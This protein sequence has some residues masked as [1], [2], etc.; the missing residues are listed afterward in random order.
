MS[1]SAQMFLCMDVCSAEF[2][3]KLERNAIPMSL[4]KQQVLK[5]P[6]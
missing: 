2:A 5:R 6:C 3:D 1:R 4:V